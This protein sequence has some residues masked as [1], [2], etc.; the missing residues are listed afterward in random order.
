MPWPVKDP[1]KGR[2]HADL[3]G[4]S[5]HSKHFD[6]P[7]NVALALYHTANAAVAL[8]QTKTDYENIPA[9]PMTVAARLDEEDVPPPG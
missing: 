8:E 1:P 2:L 5:L 7:L 6:G 3:S 9:P 4:I